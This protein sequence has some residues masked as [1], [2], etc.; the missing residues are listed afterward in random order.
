VH[1][2]RSQPTLFGPHLAARP[3]HR[4]DDVAKP[5][6][7]RGPLIDAGQH[8]TPRAVGHAGAGSGRAWVWVSRSVLLWALLAWRPLG[9]WTDVANGSGCA[10]AVRHSSIKQ[11]VL[12]ILRGYSATEPPS[13]KL[14]IAHAW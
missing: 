10:P 7:D 13:R 2:F 9:I 6:G 1:S 4:D 3:A 14:V 8:R 11:P 12:F 5:P